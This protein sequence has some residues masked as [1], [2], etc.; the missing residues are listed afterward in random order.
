MEM[1]LTNI[2]KRLTKIHSKKDKFEYEELKCKR[3]SGRRLD[4]KL[5]VTFYI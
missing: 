5:K 2:E 3:A 4:G 1:D